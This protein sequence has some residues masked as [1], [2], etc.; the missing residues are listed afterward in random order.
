MVSHGSRDGTPTAMISLTFRDAGGSTLSVP[1]SLADGFR[2]FSGRERRDALQVDGIGRE[3]AKVVLRRDAGDV[4]KAITEDN[5]IAAL[6]ALDYF[7][8]RFVDRIVPLLERKGIRSCWWSDR[9]LLPALLT[10]V[11]KKQQQ[12][13]S[14]SSSS[15]SS[16]DLSAFHHVLMMPMFRSDLPAMLMQFPAIVA[17][18]LDG[19]QSGNMGDKDPFAECIKEALEQL[20][21]LIDSHKVNVSATELAAWLQ[22]ATQSD[23]LPDA[24]RKVFQAKTFCL[25]TTNTVEHAF[26]PGHTVKI[27]QV[28]VQFSASTRAHSGGHFFTLATGCGVHQDPKLPIAD[29]A[30]FEAIYT[31]TLP[32][33]GLRTGC[34]NGTATYH[35]DGTILC[36]ATM[37]AGSCC[38]AL[39]G[40]R[41]GVL[42]GTRVKDEDRQRAV[43]SGGGIATVDSV[44]VEVTVCEYPLRSMALHYFKCLLVDGSWDAFSVLTDALHTSAADTATRNTFECLA[45]FLA[46]AL[47]QAPCPEF[48][49][50]LDGVSPLRLLHGWWHNRRDNL[51]T[52]TSTKVAR[53]LLD[54][55]KPE[56]LA[57]NEYLG[58]V[59]R[60]LQLLD[61]KIDNS[62]ATELAQTLWTPRVINDPSF[63]PPLLMSL[64]HSRSP[65]GGSP[66]NSPN[67]PPS[68][69]SG[70]KRPH[71]AIA[72]PSPTDSVSPSIG[73][74]SPMDTGPL[75][76]PGGRSCSAAAI[77]GAERGEGAHKRLKGQ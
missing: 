6:T 75:T 47:A 8:C 28:Q 25:E 60:L 46:Y 1:A 56:V 57:E 76:P 52:W 72:A 50:A 19:I 67:A 59:P 41:E 11:S 69:G 30:R 44:E 61:P 27:G 40:R 15:A 58:A 77:G 37:P 12:P 39:G 33:G 13:Y 24:L 21:C 55:V 54:R 29:I 4:V 14:P 18:T 73:C 16:T 65:N 42:Q 45:T 43:V 71:S 2:W 66:D 23:S 74:G 26:Q 36:S 10:E 5:L 32:C 62:L 17:D 53:L 7:G 3:E 48:D 68:T 9:S 34:F 51:T 38:V 22:A 49:A 35:V 70:S 31:P 20:L 64:I 63:G